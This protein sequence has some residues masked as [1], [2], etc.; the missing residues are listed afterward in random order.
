MAEQ[1][2]ERKAFGGSDEVLFGVLRLTFYVQK[3]NP[4]LPL[5]HPGFIFESLYHRTDTTIQNKK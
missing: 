2:F 4:G 5:V 1:L 3:I